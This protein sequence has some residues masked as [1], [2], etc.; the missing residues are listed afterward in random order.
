MRARTSAAL[1]VIFWAMSLAWGQPQ[2]T[3]AAVSRGKV[4]LR[5]C[6]FMKQVKIFSNI[7][8]PQE[9]NQTP[10]ILPASINLENRFSTPVKTSSVPTGTGSSESSV[11]NE[12]AYSDYLEYVLKSES[13]VLQGSLYVLACGTIRGVGTPGNQ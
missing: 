12:R 7:S 4:A 2:G 1:V 3:E 11:F 9:F 10:K 8:A 5:G 6:V 13:I